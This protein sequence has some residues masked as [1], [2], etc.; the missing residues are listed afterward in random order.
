MYNLVIIAFISL[1]CLTF[2]YN[3]LQRYLISELKIAGIC[4]ILLNLFTTFRYTISSANESTNPM[5]E[6]DI[7]NRALFTLDFIGIGFNVILLA[8]FIV[9]G[10]IVYHDMR[11]FI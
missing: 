8:L 10:N 5:E 6:D 9:I 3:S 11:E 7:L 4:F 1:F 2:L